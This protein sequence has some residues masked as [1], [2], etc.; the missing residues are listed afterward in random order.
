MDDFVWVSQGGKVDFNN[1]TFTN[2]ELPL[3]YRGWAGGYSRISVGSAVV[4]GQRGWRNA[5]SGDPWSM[6]ATEWGTEIVLTQDT[7]FYVDLGGRDQGD[8][9]GI[10]SGVQFKWATLRHAGNMM[11]RIEAN[12]YRVRLFVGDGEWID[13]SSNSGDTLF[14]LFRPRNCR[15]FEVIGNEGNP[16]ACYIHGTGQMWGYMVSAG[17]SDSEGNYRTT[18]GGVDVF[19]GFRVSH[20]YS[21]WWVLGVL[22]SD[23]TYFSYIRNCRFDNLY[24][25]VEAWAYSTV[26]VAENIEF[27]QG[28]LHHGVCLYSYCEGGVRNDYTI[29]G[30]NFP[31]TCRYFFDA[32]TYC[33]IK[34][35]GNCINP[36]NWPGYAWN[37]Y[38]F[39]M[40]E[41]NGK[42]QPGNG[43]THSVSSLVDGYWVSQ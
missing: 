26:W 34:T 10:G 40:V 21:E 17:S 33:R 36:G 28:Y 37:I 7:D 23:M 30:S 19:S 43:Q 22:A 13:S 27:R 25:A 9:R 8:G 24:D 14:P 35:Q 41:T 15:R 42:T 29:T 1:H 38:Q 5:G 3:G 16:D 12:G 39:S 18:Y 4:P 31:N 2:P 11:R 20:D 32:G 6:N